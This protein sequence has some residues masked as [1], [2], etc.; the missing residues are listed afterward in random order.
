MCYQGSNNANEALASWSCS[1]AFADRVYS[2]YVC[3]YNTAACGTQQ[4]FNLAAVNSTASF[5]VTSL[6]LGQ[7][8]FYKVS[9]QCGAPAFKP[10]DISR[11]EIE[12][13]EFNDA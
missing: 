9:A 11:V 6:S 10:T 4:F 8:C 7:T 1:S 12:Y 5:N 3:Q 2:K 13:V